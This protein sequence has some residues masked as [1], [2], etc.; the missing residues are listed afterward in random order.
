M[1]EQHNHFHLGQKIDNH[2]F[3]AGDGAVLE[4]F[5]QDMVNTVFVGLSNIME[6]E[7]QALANSLAEIGVFCSESGGCLIV[8][9]LGELAFD[10]QFNAASIPDEFFVQPNFSHSMFTLNL[11]VLDTQ[12]NELKVL[13]KLS[14]PKNLADQFISITD[15]QR[16]TQDAM[17]I[18]AE[19]GHLLNTLSTEQLLK[20]ITLI[21][22]PSIIT[23]SCNCGQNH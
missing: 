7:Q 18:N 16:D 8:L 22:V 10:I 14:I 17:R 6:D 21:S 11:M 13:R 2:P 9:K 23:P 3:V 20:K 15:Q 5:R 1:A 19:N 4:L 12:S